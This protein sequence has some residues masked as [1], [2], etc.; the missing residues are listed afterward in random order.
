MNKIR[1]GILGYGNVGKGVET[2][3][4]T[5]NDIELSYIFTRRDP[6]KIHIAS[7]ATVCSIKE[8]EKYEDRVDVLILCGGSATDLPVQGPMYAR[9]FNTVDSFDTHAKIQSYFK[10][11]DK[12]CN[13]GGKVSMISTGWDPG[14]FS[15]NRVLFEA[16]LPNGRTNTFWGRGVSQGHSEA[17]RRIN[18]VKDAVEYTIPNEK[19]VCRVREGSTEKIESTEKHIRECFVVAMD[20]A[21]KREIEEEITNMPHYFSGYNTVVHFITEE[22]LVRDHSAMPHGGFVFRTGSTGGGYEDSMEF[23]LSLENN[24]EFTAS[25]LVAC[26]RAVYKL[27]REGVVGAKTILDIPIA[28]LIDQTQEEI[29]KN[30]L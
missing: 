18:G 6:E 16:I 8:I 17:I 5:A 30:M 21:D 29:L 14:L 15:L 27:S 3:V 12:A 13:E 26:A 19:V 28:Y 20:S 2:V 7:P 1:I 11:V 9:R 24:P 23:R 10:E 4:Q 22:E 25:V